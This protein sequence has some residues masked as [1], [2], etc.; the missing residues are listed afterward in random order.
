M[1]EERTGAWTKGEGN[2]GRDNIPGARYHTHFILTQLNQS[3]QT[4]SVLS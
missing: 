4:Q 1:L 2:A 3:I